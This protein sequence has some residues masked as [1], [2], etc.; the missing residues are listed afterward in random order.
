MASVN[1]VDLAGLIS[2]LGLLRGATW[3]TAA[4][5]ST[6]ASA[7]QLSGGVVC[8]MNNSGANPGTYTTRTA[9]QMITDS[10]LQNGQKYIVILCNG[11][12]TGTLTLGGGTG[13]TITGTATVAANVLRV[14]VVSIDTDTTMTFTN[15]GSG[16]AP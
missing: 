9:R 2:G 14:Y 4:L 1:D 8:V 5:S 15:A 6:T 13:V 11:Q 7:G 10:N 3:N 16:V 12:A